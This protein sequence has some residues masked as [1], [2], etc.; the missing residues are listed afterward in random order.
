LSSGG[1][2]KAEAWLAGFHPSPRAGLLVAFLFGV[3][4]RAIPELLSYPYPIGF[5][6]IY[7]AW[8][9]KEGVVWA[10]W[11]SVFGSWLLYA[12]LIPVYNALRVEPFLLLKLAMPLLFGVCSG[13]VYYM[14][15]K[16]FGWSVRKGL[17]AAGLFS[18]QVAA[19]GISWHFYR[20]MLGL[21]ILLFALPWILRDKTELK[22]L[23]VFAVL[24]VLAVFSHE[25]AS[26]LLLVSVAGVVVHHW[27]KGKRRVVCGVLLAATPAVAIFGASVFFRVSP[28]FEAAP[29]NVLMAYG[30]EGHYSGLLFFMTNYL[31]VFDTVQ[32]YPTY[33]DLAVSVASLSVVLYLALLPLAVAG[34]FRDKVL[35][36]WTVLLCA[37]AFG[38]LALPVLALDY[39]SRWMLM[40][41]FP[42]TYYAASGFVRVLKSV[43]PVAVSFWRLGSL[44]ISWN[45]ARGLRLTN[46]SRLH[47]FNHAQ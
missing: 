27:L 20:N 29:P 37:G 46:H 19:L 38:C 23:A 6:T 43:K 7:Y 30:R 39:W 26:V 18:F 22:G 14:A 9:V 11:S 4:V 40:L 31:N 12:L 44:R 28:V 36:A 3:A 34:F 8:R 2:G 32:Y 10:H 5:D 15:T 24:S 1:L 45:A 13:G 42:L 47:T 21:G 33:L 16:G 17:F 25:Y 35:D 41:V